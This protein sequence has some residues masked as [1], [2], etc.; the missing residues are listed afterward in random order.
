MPPAEQLAWL[1]RRTG[2]LESANEVLEARLAARDAQLEAAQA[3]LAVLAQQIEEL[4][5]QL[6]RDSSTSSRPPSSDNPYKKKPRDRSLRG[7]SGR[8]PGKQPGAQSSTPRQSGAPRADWQAAR[9]ALGIPHGRA[10]VTVASTGELW[11]RRARYERELAWAP[12]HVVDDLRATATARREHATQASLIRARARAA[13]PGQRAGQLALA[14]AHQ[15][16]ADSLD[17]REATLSCIDAQRARWHAATGQARASAREATEELRRR[18]PDADLG[19]FHVQARDRARSAEHA[20]RAISAQRPKLTSAALRHAAE[21]A[22]AARR[23]LDERSAHAQRDA[24]REHQREAEECPERWPYRDPGYDFA[25]R[26]RHAE[27]T[28]AQSR[29]AERDEPEAAL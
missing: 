18:L 8:K 25:A 29:Q 23:T 17:L 24:Q 6:G 16:L 20:Q 12:P 22:H 3:R 9:A 1:V 28:A 7:R 10:E 14:E 15:Q 26:Q 13:Q 2:E 27:H 21:L 5:R 11:A 19:P 4:R